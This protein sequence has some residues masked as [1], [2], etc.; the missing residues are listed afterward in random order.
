MSREN[1]II[2]PNNLPSDLYQTLMRI[3]NKLESVEGGGVSKAPVAPFS[4]P[5]N[6]KLTPLDIHNVK[7]VGNITG[8][9]DG[10]PILANTFTTITQALNSIADNTV[11][12]QYAIIVFPGTYTENITC[13][14]YVHIIGVGKDAVIIEAQVA[15]GIVMASMSFSNVTLSQ[16]STI[17]DVTTASFIATTS[18][19]IRSAIPDTTYTPDFGNNGILTCSYIN[20][21]GVLKFD[22]SA[23]SGATITAA[24]LLVYITYSQGNAAGFPPPARKYTIQAIKRDYSISEVTWNS[25]SS[26]NVW[27]VSGVNQSTND[28]TNLDADPGNNFSRTA[29]VPSWDTITTGLDSSPRVSFVSMIQGIVN[30]TKYGLLMRS[31]GDSTYEIHSV[32]DGYSKPYLN[33]TYTGGGA[34]IV[35]V[36]AAKTAT[37]YSV[38]FKGITGGLVTTSVAVAVTATLYALDCKH[39]TNVRRGIQNAGTTHSVGNVYQTTLYDLLNQGGTFYTAGD[40]YTTSS[41]TITP[42]GNADMVDGYH[43]SHS[44]SSVPVSDTVLNIDLNADLLDGHHAA[45]FAQRNFNITVP[46]AY[47]YV[48]LT[49]DYVI[50]ASAGGGTVE[51]TLPAAAGNTGLWFHIR[52][53]DATGTVNVVGGADTYSVDVQDELLSVYSNGTTWEVF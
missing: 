16:L 21:Y 24:S 49:T 41:G 15:S 42:R 35:S 53:V 8:L 2:I 40:E 29:T 17:S 36:P 9:V 28:G 45:F 12:N 7:F 44:T 38:N 20:D 43:A 25:Y 37:L 39:D 32:K 23:I 6:V 5:K 31:N 10:Q 3:K 22:L 52:K 33:L 51:C 30:G 47:P 1:L 18:N 50:E 14:D 19:E 48:I 4:V 46:G 34:P 26:G 11:T 13:K 27:Q